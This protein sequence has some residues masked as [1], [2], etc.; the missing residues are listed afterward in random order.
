VAEET[1]TEKA[2]REARVALRN[3][4]TDL[5]PEEESA[6]IDDHDVAVRVDERAKLVQTLRAHVAGHST[7]HDAGV[8][9][10]AS[11]IERISL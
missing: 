1:A 10:A 2:L 6:L 3:H 4:A 5:T 9:Y 11:L 8:R 7:E